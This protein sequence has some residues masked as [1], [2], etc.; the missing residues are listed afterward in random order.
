MVH[1]EV[2]EKVSRKESAIYRFDVYLN[3]Y[4]TLVQEERKHLERGHYSPDILTNKLPSV[5]Y[6]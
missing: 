3:N 2:R 4:F 6:F 1:R 5:F